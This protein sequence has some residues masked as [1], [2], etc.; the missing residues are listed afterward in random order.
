[1]KKL[2]K[3]VAHFS[4]FSVI[5]RYPCPDLNSQYII[6]C[7]ESLLQVLARVVWRTYLYWTLVQPS[8]S[9]CSA[10]GRSRP[11][12][13]ADQDFPAKQE[14]IKNLNKTCTKKVSSHWSWLD[15]VD[16]TPARVNR[17]FRNRM[18]GNRTKSNTELC[19]SSISEPI[20]LNWINRVRQPNSIK[21]NPMDYVRLCSVNKFALA[22][23]IC[24]VVSLHSWLLY[25]SSR[26]PTYKA[27]LS[28]RSFS[29]P[30]LNS[31]RT[32]TA[33]RK[34]NVTIEVDCPISIKVTIW[35]CRAYS[36]LGPDSW[37]PS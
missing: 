17:T 26:Q 31:F 22:K 8:G 7:G 2:F 16:H 34:W 14:Q 20:E 21:H 24:Y 11:R 1:M 35:L 19:V 30:F 6:N 12:R 33:I 3:N 23:V 13:E 4:K 10:G 25:V 27:S 9:D 32:I 29:R 15:Y 28:K 18:L 36:N 5:E 37:E